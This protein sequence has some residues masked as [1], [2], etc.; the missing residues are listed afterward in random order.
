LC[1]NV[2]DAER[3]VIAIQ[4]AGVTAMVGYMKRHA[5][6]VRLAVERFREAENPRFVQC[7]LWQPSDDRYLAAVLDELPRRITSF[8]DSIR[9]RAAGEELAEKMDGDFGSQL[10]LEDRIRERRRSPS[11]S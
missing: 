11:S 4:E 9:S 6:G 3:I 10:T 1:F 8:L 7:S 2:R 5:P